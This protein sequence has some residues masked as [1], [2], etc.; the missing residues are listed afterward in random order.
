VADNVTSPR[1]QDPLAIATAI[2]LRLGQAGFSPIPV[3]GKRPAPQKWQDK[4]ATNA[5][6]IALWEQLYPDATNTGI[7]TR[8]TPA[9]DVDVL[10]PEAAAAVEEL[11]RDRFTERGRILVG[12]AEHRSA[13]SFFVP[14]RP[15]RR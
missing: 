14:A 3:N 12:S 15:S 10:D 7:L 9:L 11:V 4:H 5:A 6:E 2:R 1:A 13:P 8:W